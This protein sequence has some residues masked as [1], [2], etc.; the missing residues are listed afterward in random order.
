METPKIKVSYYEDFPE[1]LIDDF[2]DSLKES[3]IE[4][5]RSKDKRRILNFIED[6]LPTIAIFLVA[7]YVSGILNKA[8]S[9]TYDKINKSI[10]KL[11]KSLIRLI[12]KI[13]KEKAFKLIAGQKPKPT[14]CN[15]SLI[16][17]IHKNIK[18]EFIFLG[19][20]NPKLL[21]ESVDT[22]F[23]TLKKKEFSLIMK[24]IIRQSDNKKINYTIR[25]RFSE[26]EKRW[27]PFDPIKEKFKDI[28]KLQDK[29]K[30]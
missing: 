26:Q 9:D 11:R 16:I 19:E 4:F 10:P 24:D 29:L 13:R 2:V 15:L 3:G 30:D 17:E 21:N 7:S 20:D 12:K 1:D 28:S 5:D 23:K 14:K 6:F 8:G 27:M 22:I 25:L 18:L